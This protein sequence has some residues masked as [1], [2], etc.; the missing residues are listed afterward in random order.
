MRPN[1]FP[2]DQLRSLVFA[3]TYREEKGVRD[4]EGRRIL[5]L[6]SQQLS[7]WGFNGPPRETT[8]V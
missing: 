4:L 2:R 6:I 5:C 1:C 8:E 7:T 3:V